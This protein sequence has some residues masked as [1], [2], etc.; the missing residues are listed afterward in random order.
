MRAELNA[1]MTEMM[2][3][4]QGHRLLYNESPVRMAKVNINEEVLTLALDEH[5]Q[6]IHQCNWH[7]TN[8]SQV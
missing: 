1:K 3:I 2:M 4:I 5:I 6:G 8:Y 7:E